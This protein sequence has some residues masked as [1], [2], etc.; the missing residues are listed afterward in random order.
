MATEYSNMFYFYVLISLKDLKLYLGFTSRHPDIRAKEH[1]NGK[2]ISTKKR[3]PFKLI[4]YEAH[5]NEND[6]R[7]REK[8][9]KSSKGKASLKQMIRNSLFQSHYDSPIHSPAK[10]PQPSRFHP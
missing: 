1:N 9:F 5:L 6:A 3:R 8:Y 2:N 10:L 7:R 4:Y